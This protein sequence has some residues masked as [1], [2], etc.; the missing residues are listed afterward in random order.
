MIA[1]TIVSVRDDRRLT[2]EDTTDWVDGAPVVL[3][4]ADDPDAAQIAGPVAGT[5]GVRGEVTL[6]RALVA[7]DGHP[8]RPTPGQALRRVDIEPEP[9]P[10]PTPERK[11]KATTRKKRSAQ[12]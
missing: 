8:V 3:V 2:L 5:L 1:H 10:E 12:S 11:K 9:A 7:P 4:E 6:R